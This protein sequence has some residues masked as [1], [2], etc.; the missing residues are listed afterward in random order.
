MT[1]FSIVLMSFL[2][3]MQVSAIESRKCVILFKGYSIGSMDLYIKL[4]RKICLSKTS[5]I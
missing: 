1:E 2:H 3:E 4:K 5:N